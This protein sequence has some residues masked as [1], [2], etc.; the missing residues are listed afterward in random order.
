MSTAALERDAAAVRA[1]A[2]EIT[3]CRDYDE[4]L[5]LAGAAE[6]VLLG[7][8]THGTEEFYAV[9][10]ELT[11]RLIVEK[12]FHAVAV[13]GDWP[14]SFRVHRHVTG[15]GADK[16][17][18]EALGDFRRFPAWMWRNTVVE[19]F[20]EWLRQWNLHASGGRGT[21]GF[22]GM[23]LYSLHTSIESVLKYLEEVDPAAA[24][25]ARGRYAC[26]DHF[27]V[28]PQEYGLATTR[29]GKEPCEEKVIMQLLELR[30]R[31]EEML[32]HGGQHE[33]E[34]FFS[35]EQNARLVMNAER[36]YRAMF[37]GR[38][39]SWNLR[40]T[41]MFETLE[42]LHQHLGKAKMVVWA[43]NSHL[44][45]ARATEMGRHGEL[46]VGELVRERFQGRS[47]A[48]GF[49]TYTGSVTAAS[50]W[51][52][53]AERKR[54]RP[55]MRG[56]YEALFHATGLP[57]FWLNLREDNAATKLLEK[58]RLER[59]IGVIYRPETERTSHY[60]EACLPGQFDVMIHI[61]ETHALQPLESSS[62]WDSGEFPETYPSAL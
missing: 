56:S 20:V 12:G 50:D 3:S 49:S 10:A 54:V 48:V 25:R 27:S 9:R 44:G 42:E 62:E 24:K 41:H 52:E 26:F 21:A 60:F 38:D 22:Y 40:D 1:A 30:Q 32:R 19:E 53:P 39:E 17:A 35:A 47:L 43:H 33:K 36:Y 31:Q 4:L 51:G 2:R 6:V 28:E 18:A 8:A 45:D 16:S 55:A 37:Y 57:R 61:D 13:E 46:N 5:E 23:D 11:R 29:H 15:R 58:E 14:D 59:A 7:E 34:D